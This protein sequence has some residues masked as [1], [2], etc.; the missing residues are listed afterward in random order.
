MNYKVVPFTAATSYAQDASHIASAV[1]N[2]M[3]FHVAACYFRQ[4][5][6]RLRVG[7][8]SGALL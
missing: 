6:S 2:L 8:K 1:E 7:E 3:K 4:T 5:D